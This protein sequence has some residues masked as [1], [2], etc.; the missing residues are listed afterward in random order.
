MTDEQRIDN[1]ISIVLDKAEPGDLLTIMSG[2]IPDKECREHLAKLA[3][4]LQGDL[5][6]VRPGQRI[7]HFTMSAGYRVLLA[8]RPQ[9]EPED[10]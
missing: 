9:Q 6:K 1:R 7:L 5:D 4:K 3:G 10:D 2:T 8:D